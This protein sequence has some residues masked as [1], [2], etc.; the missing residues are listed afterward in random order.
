ML[1]VEYWHLTTKLIR[2]YIRLDNCENNQRKYNKNIGDFE[3]TDT[4]LKLCYACTDINFDL[5]C[6]RLIYCSI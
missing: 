5:S 6:N 1:L 2:G 4:N 3:I